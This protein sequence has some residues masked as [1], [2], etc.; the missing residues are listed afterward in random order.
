MPASNLQSYKLTSNELSSSTKQNNMIDA[1]QNDLNAIDNAKVSNT[2]AIAVSKLAAGSNGDVLST[3]AG[4]P[5]WG[6]TATGYTPTLTQSG[7]VTKTVTVA[8]Y[9]QLGKFV[10][11][12]FHLAV[13]GSG[14]TNNAVLVGLPV[15]ANTTHASSAMELGSGEILDNGTNLYHV[16]WRYNSSTTIAALRNDTLATSVVGVDPNFALAN[17]DYIKGYVTYLAA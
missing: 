7:S 5:T 15:T 14:T 12:W 4:V 16:M 3:V 17:T 6:V 10:T 1:I 8:D 13:T 11:V 9:V 2:A